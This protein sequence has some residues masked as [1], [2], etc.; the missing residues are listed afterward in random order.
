[1]EV[2]VEEEE[3]R[4]EVGSRIPF[5]VSIQNCR[6]MLDVAALYWHWRKSREN[7]KASEEGMMC[8]HSFKSIKFKSKRKSLTVDIM[9]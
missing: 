6:Q 1:M 7:A 8:G 3:S 9:I 4:A 5:N 2:T